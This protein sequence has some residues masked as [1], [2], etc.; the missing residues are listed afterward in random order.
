MRLQTL[1]SPRPQSRPWPPATNAPC[2]LALLGFRRPSARSV[3]EVTAD[4]D[5]EEIQVPQGPSRPAARRV[6]GPD[7]RA[8]R[9]LRPEGDRPRLDHEPPDRGGPDRDD[10]QEQARRQGLDQRLPGQ[11]L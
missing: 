3:R 11:E 4:V 2:V 7:D 8:V 10:A 9:R 6:E 1:A 5:A